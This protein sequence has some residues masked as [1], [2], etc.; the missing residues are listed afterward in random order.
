[1]KNRTLSGLNPEA[2]EATINGHSTAL[3]CLTNAQGAEVCVTNFGGFIASVMVPDRSGKMVDV[4]LGHS[5]LEDYLNTPERYLGS[6]IG[7][8]ANRIA[9][10]QFTLEGKRFKLAVNNGPNHLHGGS[11]GFNWRVWNVL[12]VASNKI[13][14][15]YFSP[16]GEEG[17]P[18][19]LS[20]VMQYLLTDDNALEISYEAWTNETTIINLT[21]HAFFNLSGQGAPTICDHEMMI[22]ASF[23]TPVDKTSIPTG[24]ILRVKGTPMDF[25]KSHVIGERI[26]EPFQQ[27]VFGKGY[28]HNYVLNKKY[29]GE[30]AQAAFVKSPVTGITLSTFTTEPGVQLYTGNWLNGFEGKNGARY[31]ERSAFC[32]ETQYFPDSPNKAHFPS[33]VLQPGEVYQHL[34][35]YA[36]GVE[37]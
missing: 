17:Y 29:E 7:R 21:N 1:M 14:M 3:Y 37:K 36:F 13:R 5:S 30:L 20:I 28:D 26:D 34:C 15:S 27:L 32:L 33:C 35:V 24:E 31:P 11:E 2:F 25:T 12:E 19:D 6:A 8:Y 9:K 10:G 18:G 4:V 16:D 22:N 23:Y